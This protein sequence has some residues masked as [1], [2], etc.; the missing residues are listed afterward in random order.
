MR[1]KQETIVLTAPTAQIARIYPA[2]KAFYNRFCA[3]VKSFHPIQ[4]LVLPDIWVRD[5]L[6][7]QNVQT[8]E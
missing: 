7:V 4:T 2:Y 1:T 3:A 6:P 8:G 5:F